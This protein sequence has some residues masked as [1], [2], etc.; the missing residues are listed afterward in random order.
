[1]KTQSPLNVGTRKY[2]LFDD[3]LVD[4]KEGFTLTMNP[5]V[6]SAEPVVIPDRPW[7]RGGIVGDSSAAVVEDEGI[8]RLWYGVATPEENVKPRK[9]LSADEMEALDRKSLLDYLSN[10]QWMLCYAESKDGIHWEKPSLRIHSL[11]GSKKNNIVMKGG[12]GGCTV[13]RDPDAPPRERYK[14]IYGGG[15]KMIHHN[16]GLPPY[17]GYHAVH[18]AASAD[19]IH[20]RKSRPI[21]PWYTDCTNV[22]YWDDRIGR[23]VAFVRW[24]ETMVCRD[25]ETFRS[26]GRFCRDIG[27]AESEDFWSFPGP[28]KIEAPTERERTPWS[29]R[30]ELY[31][32]AAVKYPWAADSYFIFPSYFYPATE[33]LDIHLGTSRDGVQCS[34]WREPFLGLGHEGAFDSTC[35][36]MATGMVR[37]D[38][39]IDMYYAGADYRHDVPRWPAGSGGIG[40]IRVRLDGFV[41]QDARPSGAHMVT[42]PLTFRGSRLEVN[43]D[44]GAGGWL[45]VEILDRA[46]KPLAGCGN[47]EADALLG[48]DVR[49]TVTWNGDS[50]VS[51]V[52]GKAVRLKFA[53]SGV[54]LYAF[55]FVDPA[56]A[57]GDQR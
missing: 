41:S 15:P 36:Y 49:K 52:N 37:R 23:Y 26:K 17:P 12:G 5:G 2:L 20:W 24:N 9:V 19:G 46:G 10:D 4:E 44:A 55:Q 47:R 53:G 57:G 48:N 54:K 7:E 8:Y 14:L 22:C 31:N 6:R 51:M 34:R 16:Q 30:L 43:M 13:F 18:G 39:E 27:R 56:G 38:H 28:R 32:S 29:R 45:K 25:G 35:L 50:D 11:D 40:R 42:V 3:A 1:M 21:M 33:T